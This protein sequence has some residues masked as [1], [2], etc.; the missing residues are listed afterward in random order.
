MRDSA[1]PATCPNCKTVNK[2]VASEINPIDNSNS[3]IA[4]TCFE[5][6]TIFGI[7]PRVEI[8]EMYKSIS[9]RIERIEGKLGL[10]KMEE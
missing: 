3:V 4:L 10:P 1:A 9:D 2:F 8:T 6:G 5:C 7:N